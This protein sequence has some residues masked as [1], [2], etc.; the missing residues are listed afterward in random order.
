MY[1]GEMIDNLI[2][3]VQ[4]AEALAFVRITHAKRPLQV[5]PSFNTYIFEFGRSEQFGAVRPTIEVA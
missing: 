3:D 5:V 1:T 4:N 2:E